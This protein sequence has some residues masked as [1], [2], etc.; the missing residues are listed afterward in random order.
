[1]SKHKYAIGTVVLVGA[2]PFSKSYPDLRVNWSPIMDQ[3]VGKTATI[4]K[5]LRGIHPSTG[6]P[7]YS[8]DIDGGLF[9]WNEDAL[10][11]VAAVDP[12]AAHRKAAVDAGVETGDDEQGESKLGV[13]TPVIVEVDPMWEAP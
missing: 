6:Q 2:H 8:I 12:Y 13:P 7:Q 11:V 5:S 3:Y 9:V 4:T 10:T 1:M